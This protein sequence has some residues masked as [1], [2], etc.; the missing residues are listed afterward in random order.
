M[1]EPTKDLELASPGSSLSLAGGA[2]SRNSRW[3]VTLLALSNV[4]TL[5]VLLRPAGPHKQQD[6]ND[7]AK[8]RG[9]QG[10]RLEQGAPEPLLGLSAAEHHVRGRGER[11][12]NNNWGLLRG[13]GER[14]PLKK[15]KRVNRWTGQPKTAATGL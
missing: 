4:V 6:F 5:A 14:I 9:A 10:P 15:D 12:T 1:V 11:R 2:S 8:A 13:E 3:A 7:A